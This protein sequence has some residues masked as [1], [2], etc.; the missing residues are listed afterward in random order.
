[1]LLLVFPFLRSHA[2][3]GYM[4]IAQTSA[5]VARRPIGAEA[6]ARLQALMPLWPQCLW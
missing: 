1:M 2:P 6:A 4:V 5:V 3:W